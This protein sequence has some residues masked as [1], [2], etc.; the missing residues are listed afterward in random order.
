VLD[1]ISVAVLALGIGGLV[2]GGFFNLLVRGPASEPGDRA[3]TWRILA[4]Y[5]WRYGLVGIALGGIGLVVGAIL[6]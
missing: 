5:M 6:S 3:E 2:A 4:P 1:Q